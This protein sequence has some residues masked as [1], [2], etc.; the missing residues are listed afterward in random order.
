VKEQLHTALLFLAV[1]AATLGVYLGGWY[2]F[3]AIQQRNKTGAAA[4]EV[5]RQIQQGC[6]VNVQPAPAP[7]VPAPQQEEAEV[8]N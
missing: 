4:V 3:A 7:P 6:S 2:A 5:I 1:V 8:P